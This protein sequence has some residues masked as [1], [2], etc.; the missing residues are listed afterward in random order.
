MAYESPPT[1][2]RLG[3]YA[4]KIEEKRKQLGLDD[5]GFRKDGT[6]PAAD[7]KEELKRGDG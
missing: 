6:D 7:I 3:I 1:G 5:K 2:H 4:E